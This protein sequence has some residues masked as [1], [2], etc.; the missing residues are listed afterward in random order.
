L[1]LHQ[2]RTVEAD[3]GTHVHHHTYKNARGDHYTH[4]ERENAATS[5]NE[6]EAGQHV[7]EQFG[8]NQQ[9]GEEE[10]PGEGGQ[11]AQAGGAMGGGAAPQGV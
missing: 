7:T 8:M 4:P 10:Q 1:H 3:D 5:M 6:K 11:E 9:P 2:I